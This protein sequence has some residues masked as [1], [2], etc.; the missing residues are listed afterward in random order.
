MAEA[1]EQSFGRLCAG[2]TEPLL[3]ALAA[4]GRFGGRV[5]RLLD[6]GTGTG[7]VARAAVAR[8]YAVE[9]IDP[10]PTM[11][12]HAATLCSG[13]EFAVGALPDLPY[14]DA[15]FDAVAAN[16]VVNHVAHP[17]VSVIEL[18]RV[19]APGGAVAATIWPSEL[20]EMNAL[21]KHV[22]EAAEAQ[23]P[24]GGRLPP[25]KD[26]ERTTAGLA[27]LFR[28]AGLLDVTSVTLDWTFTI[29]PDRLWLAAEAG[30]ATI[31]KTYRSQDVATQER[32]RRAYSERTDDLSTE[33]FL[34]FRATAILAAGNTLPHT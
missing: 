13:I 3:D 25:D 22:I 8:G 21:W 1:Y 11:V 29:A 31:G 16:F 12:A 23:V 24:P 32:M 19:C 30:I 2:T 26:F 18:A 28:A 34:P 10:E 9:A 20:S 17:L 27:G 33:G 5:P 7:A 4:A 14:P 15:A 6:V